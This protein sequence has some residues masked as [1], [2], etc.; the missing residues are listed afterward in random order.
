MS[1]EAP[2][3]KRKVRKVKSRDT[4]RPISVVIPNADV[5]APH[6]AYLVDVI[7]GTISDTIKSYANGQSIVANM[8]ALTIQLMEAV[9]NYPTLSN[10]EKKVIVLEVLVK[11]CN[12]LVLDDASATAIETIIVNVVPPMIDICVDVAKGKYD[13]V[14]KFQTLRR[15]CCKG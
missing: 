14:Q 2:K 6:N 4:T 10:P 8:S 7:Y 12:E 3:Q 15:W 13:I 11:A 9:Q 1:V 5:L